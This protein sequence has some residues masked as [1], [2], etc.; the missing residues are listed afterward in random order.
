[1]ISKFIDEKEPRRDVEP[2][3][4]TERVSA[5]A[6]IALQYERG[7]PTYARLANLDLSFRNIVS[8][9]RNTELKIF[10]Q[11]DPPTTNNTLISLHT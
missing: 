5:E 2:Y 6:T 1:M 9:Y 7:Q 8:S 10:D 11:V 4:S 3:L